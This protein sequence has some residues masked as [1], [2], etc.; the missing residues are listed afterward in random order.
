MSGLKL[1]DLDGAKLLYTEEFFT[2]GQFDI[3]YQSIIALPF[4]RRT[5]IYEIV[6]MGN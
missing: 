1:I 4:A 5:V 2:S 6:G 3:Y